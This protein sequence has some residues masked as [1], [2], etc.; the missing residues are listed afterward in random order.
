VV[1]VVVP[2]DAGAWQPWMATYLGNL[3][4]HPIGLSTADHAAGREV[5]N[6]LLTCPPSCHQG[7]GTWPPGGRGRRVV[8]VVVVPRDAGAWQ[9]GMATYL[10]NLSWHPIWVTLSALDPYTTTTT[11]AQQSRAKPSLG[12]RQVDNCLNWS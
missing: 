12:G 5:D 7:R 3:S 11:T 8:L 2:R 1:V 9:P 10:G 6:C 4:W